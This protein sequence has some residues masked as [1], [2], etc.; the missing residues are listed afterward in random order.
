MSCRGLLLLVILRRR[1]L[2]VWSRS[3]LGSVMIAFFAVLLAFAAY[4]AVAVDHEHG[5]AWTYES[6]LDLEVGD[7]TVEVFGNITYDFEEKRN[8]IVPDVDEYEVNV[9]S[10]HGELSG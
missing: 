1:G 9:V 6:T 5:E 2:P 7:Y 10:V 3:R 8:L 4:P